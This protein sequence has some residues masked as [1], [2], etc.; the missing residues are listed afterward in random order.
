[1]ALH[2]G[3]KESEGPQPQWVYQTF[4]GFETQTSVRDMSA[5]KTDAAI[6]PSHDVTAELLLLDEPSFGLAADM[7]QHIFELIGRSTSRA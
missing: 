6:G 2:A 4:P 7:V 1:L 3:R 5:A